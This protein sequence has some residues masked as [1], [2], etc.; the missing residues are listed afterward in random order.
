[1]SRLGTTEESSSEEEDEGEEPIFD[2]TAD[3]IVA[4]P[5][6]GFGGGAALS[7]EGVMILKERVLK[8]QEDDR[9]TALERYEAMIARQDAMG[10][11]IAK[12]RDEMRSSMTSIRERFARTNNQ[13][14]RI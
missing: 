11:R 14:E 7:I 1:M 2:P 12:F 5:S 9:V 6:Q 13:L 3:P 10:V 4:D 8:G